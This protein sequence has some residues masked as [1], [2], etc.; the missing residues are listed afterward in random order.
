MGRLVPALGAVGLPEAA[1]EVAGLP[2]QRGAEG[3]L[4]FG[5]EVHH[6]VALADGAAGQ[7]LAPIHRGRVEG[8][9][10]AVGI[11]QHERL[12]RVVEDGAQVRLGAAQ[13]VLGAGLLRSGANPGERPLDRGAD[14]GEVALEQI[15]G[16]AGLHAADRGL[17]IDRPGDDEERHCRDSF[18]RQGERR[19]AVESGEGVVGE[20]QIRREVVD[21]AEERLARIHPPGGEWNAGALE[22]VLDELR[23]HGHILEDENAERILCRWHA[24]V[25]HRYIR[26]QGDTISK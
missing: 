5:N 26:C 12:E 15:V 2:S 7:P 10:R 25:W 8:L 18:P 19:H 13:R 21:L 1:L 3:V 9:D 16:G 23:V 22:L 24:E 17:L 20:D 11:D 6:P 4:R 14:P